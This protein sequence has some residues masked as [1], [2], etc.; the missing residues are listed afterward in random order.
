MR[1]VGVDYVMELFYLCHNIYGGSISFAHLPH[2]GGIQDQGLKLIRCFQ[3][4][5][6]ELIRK[7]IT[8]LEASRGKRN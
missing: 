6:D 4:I 1:S 2:P 3:V 5:K 7:H 8:M